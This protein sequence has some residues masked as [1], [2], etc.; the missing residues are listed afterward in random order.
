MTKVSI[1]KA[2]EESSAFLGRE[3][4]LVAPV[5]LAMFA[6]PAALAAWI[7]PTGQPAGDLSGLLIM[8][9][10]L[11]T[12][13]IGQMAIAAM[14]IGWTGSV[15]GALGKAAGRAPALFG[16]ALMVFLPLAI[17]A[18]ILLVLLLGNA[19][20][21]DPASISA[22]TMAQV[23]GLAPFMLV[24]ML[25]FLFVATR[26]MPM[27]AVAITETGNPLRIVGRC[28]ALTKGNFFR[29]F[30]LLMLILVA[31]MVAGGAVTAVVGSLVVLAMGDVQPLN[32]PA[33]LIALAEGIVGAMITAVAATM[34][35]RIYVQLNTGQAGVPDV[36]RAD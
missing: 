5:A 23:P 19:G 17:A 13:L 6:V 21:T 8:L 36:D 24:M 12:A 1:G 10:V 7:N 33:L 34:V 30:V 25:V 20:L 22:E 11:A 35:A 32:L 28:F 26:L 27:S 16:A 14:A 31:A 2:W 3:A 29:L 9:F 15:G 18:A 4:R